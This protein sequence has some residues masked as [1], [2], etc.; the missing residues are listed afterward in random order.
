MKIFLCLAIL[1]LSLFGCGKEG[2]T[3]Y[4]TINRVQMQETFEG[5]YTFENGGYLEI[6]N[7][8]DND[9]SV[10]SSNLYF[11]NSDGSLANISFSSTIIPIVD[12]K[13]SSILISLNVNN[14][15]QFIGNVD[16]FYKDKSLPANH[17]YLYRFYL[18][19]EPLRV[20]LEIYGK[21]K[22]TFLAYKKLLTEEE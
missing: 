7:D 9:L 18:E 16:G 14:A 15:K 2:S 5:F 3:I 19:K 11:P 6:Y 17:T 12:N 21:N 13:A 22:N 4:Q 8:Y 10:K 1:S 20:T